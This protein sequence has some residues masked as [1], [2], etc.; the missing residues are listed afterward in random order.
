MISLSI[1]KNPWYLLEKMDFVEWKRTNTRD[2]EHTDWDGFQLIFDDKRGENGSSSLAPNPQFIF[3]KSEQKRT[4]KHAKK[5]EYEKPQKK[6]FLVA[7]TGKGDK[8]EF[9]KITVV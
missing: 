2:G 7:L 8:G 5:I 9:E 6:A 1:Q 4:G 3:E